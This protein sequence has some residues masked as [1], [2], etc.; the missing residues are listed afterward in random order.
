MH[1][2]Y[3]SYIY[4]YC[5]DIETQ[6]SIKKLVTSIFFSVMRQYCILF[7]GQAMNICLQCG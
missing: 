5:S 1:L 7:Y 3:N 6:K 4:I 2:K